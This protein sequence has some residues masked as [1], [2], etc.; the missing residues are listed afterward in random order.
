MRRTLFAGLAVLVVAVLAG[1]AAWRLSTPPSAPSPRA[2]GPPPT[3]V[4]SPRSG[5][6][7]PSFDIVRVTP[8]GEAVIAG[9]AEP[10]AEVIV[11]DGVRE[12]GRVKANQNGEWVL[13]PTEPLAPGPHELS[14]DARAPGA[15]ARSSEGVVAL[16]IPERKPP[17]GAAPTSQSPSDS[18]AVLVPRQG[19]GPARAL[20]VP[21]GK[22]AKLTLDVIEYDGSGKVQLLGRSEP[23]ARIDAALDQKP[24][25]SAKTEAGGG[26]GLVLDGNLAIGRYGLRLRATG[27]SG[28]RLGELSLSFARVAPPE[29]A[30]AVDI[31]PGN[32]LWRI[33]QHSYGDGL[34][35]TEIYRANQP[36]IRDPNLI[37]PGQ[38][39][40]VPQAR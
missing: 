4:Q 24:A 15:S 27:E 3:V 7:A 16:L 33:A 12:L 10:G 39:F 6:A 28:Q 37:Y 34:R 35:Y 21:R 9:R 22:S 17:P 30:V 1:L 18:V 23:G 14:L 11:R 19:S 40:A 26:W 25:G 29:G 5:P 32:N 2:S 20:Q 8:Q 36:Q 13:L 31:Q 38:I